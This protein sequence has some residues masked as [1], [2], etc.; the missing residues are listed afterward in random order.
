ME[1]GE[2]TYGVECSK[3][4]KG[5]TIAFRLSMSDKNDHARFSHDAIAEICTFD[6]QNLQRLYNMYSRH[7]KESRSK[8]EGT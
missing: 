2:Y 5:P 6:I 4:C 1:K 3:I 7:K 8:A